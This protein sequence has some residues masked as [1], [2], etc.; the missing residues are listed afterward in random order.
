MD[1]NQVFTEYQAKITVVAELYL[2]KYLQQVPKESR[3]LDTAGEFLK[4]HNDQFRKEVAAIGVDMLHN[5]GL[6]K[7]AQQVILENNS[8]AVSKLFVEV[9]NASADK[10]FLATKV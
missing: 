8:W 9:M 3:T 5:H 6:S 1:N 10:P 7:E 4:S 2:S